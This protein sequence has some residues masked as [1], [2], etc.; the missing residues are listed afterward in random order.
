M[1]T[2]PIATPAPITI[3]IKI[4]SPVKFDAEEAVQE[5]PLSS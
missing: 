4:Q 1:N 3:P 2:I 5:F